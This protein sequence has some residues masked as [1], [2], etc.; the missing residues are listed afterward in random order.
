MAAQSTCVH[1]AAATSLDPVTL[2][3]QAV[4]SLE[5]CKAMLTANEPM[6]LFAQKFLAEAQQ[7]V[8]ALSALDTSTTAH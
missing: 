4:N 1:S 7:A 3:M 5:R 2:H 8:A 6:Y